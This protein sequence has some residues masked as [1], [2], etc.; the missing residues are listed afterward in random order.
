MRELNNKSFTYATV[1]YYL[2]SR[3]IKVSHFV[4]GLLIKQIVNVGDL[5]TVSAPSVAYCVRT[6]VTIF[7]PTYYLANMLYLYLHLTYSLSCTYF[8]PTD[9][10]L[11]N[12]F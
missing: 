10:E 7:F 2:S 6:Y 5:L 4:Y 1:K 11:L 8:I 3:V 12:F 9:Y